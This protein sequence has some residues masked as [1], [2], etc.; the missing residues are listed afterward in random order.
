MI[1]ISTYLVPSACGYMGCDDYHKIDEPGA[2][3]ICKPGWNGHA[4]DEDPCFTKP[5]KNV[6]ICNGAFSKS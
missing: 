1:F 4:C 6:G 5:C 2:K 3:C